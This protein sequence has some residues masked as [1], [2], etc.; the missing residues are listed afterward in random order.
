MSDSSNRKQVD[1]GSSAWEQAIEDMR[2]LAGERAAEGW[3]TVTVHAGETTPE[4]PSKGESD[5]FGIVYT[6]ADNAA[7]EIEKITDSASMDEY[8]V[9]RRHVGKTLFLV[10]EF[11]DY[12][13][14]A[15]LF[16][17]GAVNLQFADQLFEVAMERGETYSH[18][19]LLDWTHLASF[20]HDDPSAFIPEEVAPDA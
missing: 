12:E 13:S 19:Q 20:R 5:R 14:E 7:Q 17:A 1:A 8:T 9:Y 10:T 16:V 6:V 4:P 2:E 11:A 18:L 15:A 3:T